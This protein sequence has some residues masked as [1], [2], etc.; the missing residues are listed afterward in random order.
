MTDNR[1]AFEAWIAKDRG[2]LSTFGSGKNMHYLNSAVN[3]AW[4]GWQ[5]AARQAAPQWLPISTAPK[6]GTKILLSNGE[7]VSE[8]EWLHAEAYIREHRDLD[9]RYVDQDESDGYDGWI[10]WGG[11]MLPDPTHWMPLPAAPEHKP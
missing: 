2:D 6:D 8:G 11:G 7:S 1:K 3:N 10:D 5:E 9:G 4:S